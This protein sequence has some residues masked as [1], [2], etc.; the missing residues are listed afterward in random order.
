MHIP[1]KCVDVTGKYPCLP[2]TIEALHRLSMPPMCLKEK[3]FGFDQG[4]RLAKGSA[5]FSH[6]T[7]KHCVV[8]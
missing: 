6:L 8:F 2:S 4:L 1:T 7:L 5:R 3:I